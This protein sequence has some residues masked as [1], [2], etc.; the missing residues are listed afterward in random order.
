[1]RQ[2]ATKHIVVIGV[3]V[4]T[5]LIVALLMIS[6]PAAPIKPKEETAWTVN[7]LKL[8]YTD[9]P[10]ELNILG[11]VESTQK[12]LITSR[13]TTTVTETPFLAGMPVKKGEILLRLESSEVSVNLIQRQGEVR[14]LESQINE[15]KLR[16][17]ANRKALVTEQNLVSL[18]EKAVA[19]QKRLAKNN[20]T[21]EERKDAAEIVLEQRKLAVINRQLEIN[22]HQ[23]KLEQLNARL[24]RAQSQ[25]TLA[26]LDMAQTQLVAP[27]DG[28]IISVS[29]A[30][31][32]RVRIGTPLIE[33]VAL[34]SLEIRAQV[35]DRWV[36]TVRS[37]LNT[38]LEH[39]RLLAYSTLADE[40]TPFSLH[41]MA[42]STTESTGGVD[43]FFRPQSDAPLTLGKSLSIT[44][45]LPTVT[46]SYA[47]PVSS[48]YGYDRIYVVKDSRLSATQVNRVG[49]FQ[50]ADGSEWIIIN[51]DNLIPEQQ[52]ITTQ[53]PN[54]VSG[55]KVKIRGAKN[56]T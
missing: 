15:Q 4:A 27:F 16:H 30:V 46:Q 52:V 47:L 17:Q 24:D 33:L 10:P 23:N 6:K 21:S 39:S 32:D 56:E 5:G 7:T 11:R 44:L 29:I 53:L 38:E 45:Q 43:A 51:G 13:V 42:A 26:E 20:V 50:K 14:E 49:R 40:R 8:S 12:S 22:N 3:I 9:H 25:L 18:A 34:N 28:W 36:P 54:A 2:D 1:M 48:I 55:L 31:G 41:R 19:R 35:P 37:L